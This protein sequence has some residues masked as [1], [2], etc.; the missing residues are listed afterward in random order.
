MD[1]HSPV[2]VVIADES[3]R[4]FAHQVAG[5]LGFSSAEIVVGDAT[6]AASVLAQRSSPPHYI[7][8]DTAD[9]GS[10]SLSS[11]D[12]MAM[13]CDQGVRVV[14]LGTVNDVHFY[15]ELKQR[16]VVEYF[17]KPAK[18][19]EIRAALM[20]I[21]SS[22][23]SRGAVVSF[24][25]AAS[26]D[27]SSTVALNTAYCL[28]NEYKQSTVLL[29]MDFQFGMAAKNLDL[30]SQYGIK[31][32]FEHPDRGIDSTL[33]DRM[34][35][36]YQGNLRLISSPNDL[37]LLPTVRPEVIRDLISTLQERFK[38]VIIDLPH[39]WTNWVSAALSNS[40]H[41]IMVAQLWLR[42]ATHATRLLGTW[43][44]IG[45]EKT[46][47]SLV[48]NRSGSRFKEAIN[49]KDF[50]RVCGKRIDRYLANDTKT[51]V[52]A[53]N[54]GKTIMEVTN[55]E[56]SQQIRELAYGLLPDTVK[57]TFPRPDAPPS[58]AS[59]LTSIFGKN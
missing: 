53:E 9:Q 10:A 13:H 50:E 43:S 21:T 27:G 49:S 32:L 23:V 28:A 17:P 14:V 48:I 7:I 59:L 11:L 37:R 15:R 35:V 51:I 12:A 41:Q 18:I 39:I 36:D 55:S 3:D 25:S 29:D 24:M 38:F 47:T 22:P 30:Q 46:S 20:N 8:V 33:I 58:K 1:E 2:M 54:L 45:I 44:D 26:G 40:S 4:L 31:E 19:S 42:S 6:D 56:L 57:N 5:S 16:G 52:D 34:L